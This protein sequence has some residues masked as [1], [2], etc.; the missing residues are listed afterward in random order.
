MAANK[1]TAVHAKDRLFERD[2]LRP[3]KGAVC[4]G[5]RIKGH[6]QQRPR[7][8]AQVLVLNDTSGARPPRAAS[9]PVRLAYRQIRFGKIKLLD[10]AIV[11]RSSKTSERAVQC[12]RNFE[13]GCLGR[14]NIDYPTRS[15]SLTATADQS[16]LALFQLALGTFRQ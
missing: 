13:T 11:P 6:I 4:F 15:S 12:W 8:P 14:L 5:W 3:C 7:C 9:N 1:V 2:V 10:V 16:L